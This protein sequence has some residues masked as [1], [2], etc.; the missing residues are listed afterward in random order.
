MNVPVSLSRE[1]RQRVLSFE[2]G[3]N[4]R[5]IGGYRTADGRTVRWRKVFRTGVLSYF[6]EG[7]QAS[8]K[9]L[10]VRAICDLRRAEERE[11]EPSRWPDEAAD[12]LHWDDGISM[13]T[14]RSFAAARPDTAAG[15][16]DAMLDLYRA[17]PV[18]MGGRIRGMFQCIANDK[19]PVVVHC[20]AGKD[21][22]GVAIAVLLRALGVPRDI[23]TGDYLLT[24]D[25]GD[26]EA[27][28]R[29]RHQA[30]LGMTDI[31]HPLLAMPPEI[32]RVLFSADAAFLDAAFEQIE[33]PLG[34]LDLYLERTVGV[35]REARE[36]AVEA[37]LTS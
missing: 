21:R 26:F 24:N 36:R 27:F 31:H 7:D 9:D 4:F 12:A 17:L 25:T 16:F 34:G 15:M 3:C 11:R 23:V 18:W 13:P 6:T 19:V 1:P 20:A 2:G 29:T 30:Q 10:E 5:D 8:L 14:I 37:L 28:I 22:T 33:G 32:R 35:T